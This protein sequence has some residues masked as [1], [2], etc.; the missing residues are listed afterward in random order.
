MNKLSAT[1]ISHCLCLCPRLSLS[2]ARFLSFFSRF[3]LFSHFS[4]SPSPSLPASAYPAYQHVNLSSTVARLFH[5]DEDSDAPLPACCLSSV[6]V[7]ARNTPPRTE[8]THTIG[9]SRP[10]PD[11][12]EY[13]P[14]GPRRPSVSVPALVLSRSALPLRS[15]S[16]CTASP[17]SGSVSPS[18]GLSGVSGRRPITDHRTAIPQR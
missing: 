2:L 7:S 8:Q 11:T 14:A 15:L 16:F 17:L 18:E 6:S 13:E 10:G 12:S 4:P 5:S 1:L 3:S 9:P